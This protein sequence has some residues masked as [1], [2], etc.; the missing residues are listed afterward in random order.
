MKKSLNI[1]PKR[2]AVTVYLTGSAVRCSSKK[3]NPTI[4][5]AFIPHH[6]LKKYNG[7]GVHSMRDWFF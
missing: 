1:D 3:N 7:L 6:G 4:K 5:F 2:A